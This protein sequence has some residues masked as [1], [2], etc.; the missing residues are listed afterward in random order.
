MTKGGMGQGRWGLESSSLSQHPELKSQGCGSGS[1][2]LLRGRK[3]GWGSRD[4]SGPDLEPLCWCVFRRFAGRLAV[5]PNP[6]VLEG[7]PFPRAENAV[8]PTASVLLP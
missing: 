6:G 3:W 2:A 5:G 1:R 4:G 7:T 8:V